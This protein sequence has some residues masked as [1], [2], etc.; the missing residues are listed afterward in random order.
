M[1]ATGAATPPSIAQISQLLW[2]AQGITSRDGGRTA[3]SAGALY[4]LELYVVAAKVEGLPKGIYK[5][6]PRSHDLL[7]ISDEDRRKEIAAAALDQSCVRNAPA[8]IAIAAVYD[9]VTGKL[10]TFAPNARVAHIDIDA[11]EIGK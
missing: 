2:A 5:Y 1:P 6:R 7:H 9:R 8:I 4:P 11:A 10:E 3:P